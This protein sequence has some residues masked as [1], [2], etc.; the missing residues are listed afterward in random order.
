VIEALAV[1]ADGDEG[2]RAV[3]TVDFVENYFDLV[4][5]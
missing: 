4:D 2:V 3:G 1:L 5:D